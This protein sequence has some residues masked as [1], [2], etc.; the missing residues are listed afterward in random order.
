MTLE[1]VLVLCAPFGPLAR[2]TRQMLDDLS[3]EGATIQ[4]A[5]AQAEVSLTRCVQAT[6]AYNFLDKKPRLDWVF[7][8]DHD[9]VAG[10][11]AVKMLIDYALILQEQSSLPQP[12]PPSL[13]GCYVN[14]HN[15]PPRIAAYKLQRADVINFGVGDANVNMVPALTGMGC[16]L[17]HRRAFMAHCEEARGFMFP[18]PDHVTSEVCTSHLIHA[19]ELAQFL[20]VDAGSDCWHWLA[21]DFDYCIRELEAGRLVYMA[22]VVFGHLDSVVL[23]PDART[24]FPGLRK[25]E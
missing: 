4:E 21:E 6:A 3:G 22:P 17:Q 13:S 5:Q 12:I 16:F 15:H 7:W 24:V 14:R 20:D 9:I 25:P 23:M 10:P 11:H 8:L 2:S 1:N 19:S 18:D